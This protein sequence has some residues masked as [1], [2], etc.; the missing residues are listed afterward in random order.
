MYSEFSKLF[1]F[2]PI[3]TAERLRNSSYLE[4]I[5]NLLS[6]ASDKIN[7]DKCFFFE[8]RHYSGHPNR[9]NN[10]YK[11]FVD[12]FERIFH[13]GNGKDINYVFG[14]PGIGKSLFFKQGV[15]KLFRPKA[16]ILGKYFEFCIDFRNIEQKRS[17][18]FYEDYT[19]KQLNNRAL[20]ILRYFGGDADECRLFYDEFEKK[21]DSFCGNGDS[22]DSTYA[23]LYSVMYFCKSVYKKYRQPAII[24]FDNIDLSCEVTQEHLRE[25][26]AKINREFAEFMKLE[27]ASKSYRIFFVTRP[28]LIMQTVEENIGDRINFP[29]PNIL[30]ISVDSLERA[31]CEAAEELDKEHNLSM[32]LTLESIVDGESIVLDSYTDVAEY[33]VRIIN[34]FLKDVW[35]REEVVNRLGSC[36]EFHCRLVNYNI[37]TFLSFL[38]DTIK[39]GG[40]KPFTKDFNKRDRGVHY[41]VYDYLEMLIRGTWRMHPGNRLISKEGR[42][43]APIVFNVFDTALY[44]GSKDMQIQHFMLN[45]RIMQWFYYADPEG[46]EYRDLV[47][48]GTG[49]VLF[50]HKDRV[51]SAM[52]KLVYV[53]I[54]YSR[55]EGANAV[56]SKR[57]PD[58]IELKNESRLALSDM[59]RFYIEEMICEL[60]YLYQ[61]ALS[62]LMLKEH[63]D[64]LKHND[65]YL[66]EKEETVCRFL[67]SIYEI[68]DINYES[69]GVNVKVF[70]QLFL[71]T[72][73]K[74]GYLLVRMIDTF[75]TAMIAKISKARKNF[76]ENQDAHAEKRLKK[77][78]LIVEKAKKLKVKANNRFIYNM[79][80]L[81][82]E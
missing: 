59:G 14:I 72:D 54:L 58:E 40:F 8:L 71:R 24:T 78:N 66:R 45:I 50:F 35:N 38:S 55:E 21:R 18:C 32:K 64:Y 57:R 82:L 20:N 75:I 4:H 15:K 76:A 2:T 43:K 34:Y 5:T 79:Y 73:G 51:E 65:A 49:I 70:G 53:G 9:P 47:D 28:E 60:E 7:D 27:K 37:R 56:Q 36:Q 12:A 80:P 67:E 11:D 19:Y 74:A 26:I 6:K 25:G 13:Y 31:I 42:N 44:N 23:K 16:N 48:E 30:E 62:S 41:S 1:E 52:K 3:N 63:V 46:C 33:F 81:N 29:L 69:Y 61:M 39:N 77:L 17:I 22:K 10:L 68:I